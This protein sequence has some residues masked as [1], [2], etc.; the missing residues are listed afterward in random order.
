[1]D[2]MG[3]EYFKSDPDIWFISSMKDDSIDYYQYVLLYTNNILAIMQNPE[4]FIRHEL[5]RMFFVKPNFIGPPNKYLRNKVPN[6][7]LENSQSA[8]SFRSSQYVQDTVKTVIDTLAQE[9]RTSPKRGKY[10][11]TS[12]HRPDTDTFPEIPALRAA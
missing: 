7:T 8:W 4:D 12:N 5:G 3:F 9:E 1:M 6:V 10:T 11:W 2:E